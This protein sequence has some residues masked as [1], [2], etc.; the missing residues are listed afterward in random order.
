MSRG[1]RLQWREGG[2]RRRGRGRSAE[3]VQCRIES[4]LGSQSFLPRGHG[5]VPT[6]FCERT[7][8]PVHPR[9]HDRHC[10]IAAATPTAVAKGGN[11]IP[12]RMAT[13]T[14][15]TRQPP[16]DLV[17]HHHRNLSSS[18][19]RRQDSI[20]TGQGN[21]SCHGD[22][23]ANDTDGV[24]KVRIT[25]ASSMSIRASFSRPSPIFLRCCTMTTPL[26]E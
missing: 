7:S 21:K 12:T 3:Q 10:S 11:Q 5:K 4:S 2:E 14:R 22:A 25:D 18:G 8:F 24:S 23:T 17:R 15:V 26:S 19:S 16:G 20:P 6:L 13:T 1:E 9:S